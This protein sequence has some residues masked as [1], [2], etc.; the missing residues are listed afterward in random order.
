[1]I[2]KI[3]LLVKSLISICIMLHTFEVK[4]LNEFKFR[5]TDTI[6]EEICL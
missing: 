5:F 3:A 1:M 6:S 4:C 2:L